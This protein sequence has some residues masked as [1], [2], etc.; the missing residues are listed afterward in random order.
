MPSF[1]SDVPDFWL[2]C[3]ELF[4]MCWVSFSCCGNCQDILLFSL[5]LLVSLKRE[6]TINSNLFSLCVRKNQTWM[7]T[8]N[9]YKLTYE[10][11]IS[12]EDW[13]YWRSEIKQ[14]KNISPLDKLSI[15]PNFFFT[16]KTKK[17]LRVQRF[18]MP[19]VLTLCLDMEEKFILPVC[20]IF[21]L[22]CVGNYKYCGLQ[23]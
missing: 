12:Y 1:V 14:F 22:F 19:R 9:N 20:N 3:W 13:N 21:L 4:S 7:R 6:R 2:S 8:K 10:P 15:F 23:T 16:L 11:R 17:N 5:F 18:Q